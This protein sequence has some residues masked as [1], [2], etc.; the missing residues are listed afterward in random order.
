[1]A[2]RRAELVVQAAQALVNAAGAGMI[3]GEPLPIYRAETVAGPRAGALRLYAG[4]GTGPLYRALAADKAALARQF[5]GWPFQGDP[6]VYLDGQALRMEAPWPAELARSVIRLRAVCRQPKGNGRWVLGVNE[7]GRNVIGALSDD[8]PNWLLGGTTGSGKTVALLSAGLQL[9]WDPSTRL[10]LVDGKLGAGLGPLMNLPGVVGPLATDVVAARDALGWVYG[11]LQRRYTVVA[12]E[13]EEAARRFTRLVVV[14]DEFQEFTGDAVVAELLRRIVSRGRAAQVH[15]LLATQHPVKAA[16]GDDSTIKRNLPGRVALKVLDA[17]ASE[18]VVGAPLP[19]ADRLQGAGDAY[20]IGGTIH[21]TQLVLVDHRDL[22]EAE[23]QPPMLD[24]W[25]AFEPEAVG[26]EPTVQWAYD[27]EE[28]A[29]SLAVAWGKYDGCTGRPTLVDALE[30]A[31][32][33]R[34]GVSRARRLLRLGRDQLEA[35][36]DMGLDLCEVPTPPV[37]TARAPGPGEIVDV[38]PLGS[39]D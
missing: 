29:Y 30:D 20:A 35:L 28:L 31:G 14:F 11:E 27:G 34:P 33:G 36:G 13:G 19:R 26:Q 8:T 6:A 1:M 24:A 7:T 21:R 23:R 38:I 37:V 39:G 25:P 5:F 18:V 15:T 32:L 4:L 12:S 16:F 10:V 22:D 2:D 3:T 17:K 9:S